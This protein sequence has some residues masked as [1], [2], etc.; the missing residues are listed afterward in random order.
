MISKP[1]VQT[2]YL[3]VCTIINAIN[4][5]FEVLFLERKGVKVD[6]LSLSVQEQGRD[7]ELYLDIPKVDILFEV[8]VCV[9]KYS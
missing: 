6:E 8:H 2:K 9:K 7:V 4:I 1:Y 3:H 5:I